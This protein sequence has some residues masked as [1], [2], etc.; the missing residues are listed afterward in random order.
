MDTPTLTAAPTDS[1]ICALRAEFARRLKTRMKTAGL[2][3]KGVE[4]RS[5]ELVCAGEAK[6]GINRTNLYPLEQGRQLPNQATLET[7]AKVLRCQPEDL[8]P[9]VSVVQEN[10]GRRKVRVNR[11]LV[12][13]KRTGLGLHHL[14]FQVDM[15][16]PHDQ[17]LVLSQIFR[18]ACINRGL[19][20]EPAASGPYSKDLPV[21][22]GVWQQTLVEVLGSAVK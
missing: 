20:L 9:N 16:L 4:R 18:R 15:V 6:R 13:T 19:D 22:K 14:R 5:I 21:D 2:D 10:R 11:A 8:V 1:E 17:A 12:R 3:K 7:L